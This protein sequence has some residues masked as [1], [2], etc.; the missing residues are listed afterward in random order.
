MIQIQV[1][2]EKSQKRPEFHG[3]ITV[4]NMWITKERQS[5]DIDHHIPSQT[6][7]IPEK[8]GNE[9]WNAGTAEAC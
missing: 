2:I 9:W 8:K 3:E 7:L 4:E 6:N 5:P 1:E